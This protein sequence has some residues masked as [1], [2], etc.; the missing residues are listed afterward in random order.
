M[1]E[2]I[3]FRIKVQGASEQ[4]KAMTALKAELN[5]L[6]VTKQKLNKE[7]KSL[8]AQFESGKLSIDQYD[9]SMEVL[10][11]QQVKNSLSTKETTAAYNSNEKALN[12]YES[13]VSGLTSALAGTVTGPVVGYLPALTSD[14]QLADAAVAMM[15]PVLKQIFRAAGEGSFSDGDQKLLI[16]MK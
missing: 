14:A 9:D 10:S 4:L 7:S 13:A 16:D 6:A 3:G 2:E 5:S 1:A 12:V 8:T 15:A 11:A